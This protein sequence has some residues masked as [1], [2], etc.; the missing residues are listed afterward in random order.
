MA[1]HV[2]WPDCR[3]VI[4]LASLVTH[5]EERHGKTAAWTS[6]SGQLLVLKNFFPSTFHVLQYVH[7]LLTIIYI[8]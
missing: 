1:C 8:I 2:V 5:I 4:S 3:D 7:F 6:Q